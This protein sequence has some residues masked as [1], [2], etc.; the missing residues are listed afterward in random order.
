MATPTHAL[1]GP[2]LVLAFCLSQ[3]LRDV[4][5]GNAFQDV[6]FFAVILVAF[7]LST[8]LFA[9]IALLRTRGQLRMLRGKTG[10]LLALNLTTALAWSSY[11]FALTHLEPAIV[12]TVHSGM[13]PLTVMALAAF[14]VRLA[15]NPS[16]GI[17]EYVS[18]AG[19]ALALI[20]LCWIVLSDSSGLAGTPE[21]INL[22]ALAAVFV[23][24]TSITISL[25]ICK[26]LHD[27]GIG[28]DTVTAVRYLG[29]IAVAALVLAHKG[30]IRGID[31]PGQ[32][33]TLAAVATAL[34]VIPLFALQVGIART[35]PL[36]AH[37]FRALSPVFVFLAQQLDGRLSHSTPTLICILAYA[38]AAVAGTLA[39]SWPRSARFRLTPGWLARMR[40]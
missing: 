19:I 4:Y 26:R 32:L 21:A 2:A 18:T 35:A 13:A 5:F 15:Q 27:D 38:A 40:T 17:G 1:A 16:I 33:A 22:A 20:G 8:M 9:A 6:D 10:T 11:F 25:L 29:L 31:T 28:A 12:N 34:I 7:L 39:H 37:I 14:G 24:G 3:A 23:S 36:T 30:E